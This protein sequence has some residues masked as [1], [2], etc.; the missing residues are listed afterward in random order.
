M[1]KLKRLASE[2]LAPPVLKHIFREPCHSLAKH[3]QLMST[4][5]DFQYDRGLKAGLL[6]GARRNHAEA[7]K[8][9]SVQFHYKVFLFSQSQVKAMLSQQNKLYSRSVLA[10]EVKDKFIRTLTNPYLVYDTNNRL[11]FAT[12]FV[13]LLQFCQRL[14]FSE[15]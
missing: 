13:I 6:Q 5:R 12:Q 9:Q 3:F 14:F 7:Y 8:R 10:A 1:Y 15:I 2:Y 4:K 11:Q